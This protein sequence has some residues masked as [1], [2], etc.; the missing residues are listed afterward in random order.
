MTLS[1]SPAV[2]ISELIDRRP[3]GALQI[4]VLILCGLAALLDGMDLQSI[5]LAAPS[6]IRALHVEPRAFA[7]VFSAA[8]LGLMLGAFVLGPLAD[9]IGRKRVL[10]VSVL[11]FGAFSLCTAFTGSLRTLLVMRFLTGLGLGGAMPSFLSLG[12]EFIPHQ[13]RTVL[14][15]V[16]WAGFPLGGVLGGLL[17]SRIIPEFGWQS[18]FYIGGSLP[19]VL[20]V[21]LMAALPESPAFLVASGASSAHIARL[22]SRIGGAGSFSPSNRFVLT[23]ERVSTRSVT[24]LFTEG[25]AGGTLLLW[26]TYFLI[27]LMLV[28][29]TAWS[30]TLLHA[31]GIEVQQ[32]GIAMAAFNLGSV[33]GTS[34]VGLMIRRWGVYP[35]L[36]VLFLIS[37][38]MLGAIGSAA[39]SFALIIGLQGLA[40][41]FLGAGSSGL[42][43]LAPIFYPVAIRSTGVGWATTMGRF[44]SFVGP[45]AVGSLVARHWEIVSIY[46]A[47]GAPALLAAI[48][49]AG[50]GLATAGSRGTTT[51]SESDPRRTA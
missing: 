36:S 49:T 31:A 14:L 33:I 42:I 25:R 13:R 8:L 7:A 39:P 47:L 37:A 18:V 30:P 24:H 15:S 35:T 22:V 6:M 9:R 4:R 45:L 44:G 17:A 27:F 16:L 19:L 29:N 48:V 20:A 23:E 46:A 3:L 50:F 32:S 41:F 12:A 43:A 10:I 11:V 26:T 38:V 5:G 2:D 34:I 28:T 40:G 51:H 1:D 21:V